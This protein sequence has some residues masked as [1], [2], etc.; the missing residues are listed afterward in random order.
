[1]LDAIVPAA[2]GVTLLVV[3]V[4][5]VRLDRARGR[6]PLWWFHALNLVLGIAALVWAVSE[7][8][9]G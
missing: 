5:G 2:S 3:A 8:L 7:Y 4:W 6:K 1:M 9:S